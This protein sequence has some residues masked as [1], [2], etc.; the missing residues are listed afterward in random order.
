MQPITFVALFVVAFAATLPE[1]QPEEPKGEVQVRE[2]RSAFLYLCGAHPHFFASVYPCGPC[3]NCGTS[4]TISCTT[5]SYC[6]T[7][8]KSLSCMSGCCT[9]PVLYSAPVVSS[10]SV[11]TTTECIGSCVNSIC[12][13]G[14]MCTA[15]HLCC[16]F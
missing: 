2:R 16:P 14:Y 8:H 6:R 1:E 3:I 4:C 5:T 12:P 9:T 13:I 10:V 7:F 11:M 15:S